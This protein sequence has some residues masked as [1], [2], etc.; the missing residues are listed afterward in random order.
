VNNDAYLC[1]R[2]GE[3]IDP[4]LLTPVE[5]KEWQDIDIEALT[6]CMVVM[7]IHLQYHNLWIIGCDLAD[8]RRIR[9]PKLRILGKRSLLPKQ[10]R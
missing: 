9:I 7:E 3:C 5:V 6:K 2:T 8:L 4:A 10:I 1:Q